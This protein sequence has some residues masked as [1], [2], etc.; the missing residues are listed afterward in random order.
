MGMETMVLFWKSLTFH[1]LSLSPPSIS[2]VCYRTN[3]SFSIYSASIFSPVTSPADSSSNGL[4]TSENQLPGFCEIL[5]RSAIFLHFAVLS[6]S[7]F[8]DPI[9]CFFIPFYLL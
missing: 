3:S 6:I 2:P 4:K 9:R 8:Y 1:F 5:L 7:L